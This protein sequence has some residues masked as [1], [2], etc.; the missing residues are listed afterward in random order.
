MGAV[1]LVFIVSWIRQEEVAT[2]IYLALVV[3]ILSIYNLDHLLDAYRLNESK[4][5]YRHSFY[6]K[7]FKM[8]IIWQAV[9]AICA[10]WVL[11]QLPIQIIIAGGI[12]SAAI[13]IY[14]IFIFNNTYKIYL[15]RESIVALGYALSVGV[16]PFF[17]SFECLSLEF[18]GIFF[19]IFF[20]A[21]TNLWVFALYEQ[22]IDEG[23]NHHSIA[24]RIDVARLMMMAKGI[25][26][27]SIIF[28]MVFLVIHSYYIIGTAFIIV[29]LIYFSLLLYKEIFRKNDFYR[30][31]GES[32]LILPGLLL[33]LSHGV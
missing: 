9:L 11:F 21:L 31:I 24:R 12:M 13:G 7:Y 27:I 17:V 2:P 20:M 8:L 5:S 16:I 33:L 1:S 29:Q 10:V 30:L 14:F 18:S 23:Q 32:I 6:K 22:E 4:S 19:I 3:S 26:I 28:I 15:L 25:I